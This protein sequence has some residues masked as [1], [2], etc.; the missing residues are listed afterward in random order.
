MQLGWTDLEPRPVQLQVAVLDRFADE[1]IAHQIVQRGANPGMLKCGL[2]I[3]RI[4]GQHLVACVI[5][6]LDPRCDE[7]ANGLTIGG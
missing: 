4:G 3:V 2:G 5:K 1:G 7:G 6:R